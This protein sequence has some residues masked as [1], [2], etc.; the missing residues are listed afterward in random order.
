ME[1]LEVW[2]EAVLLLK[3]PNNLYVNTQDKHYKFWCIQPKDEGYITYWARIG[4]KIQSKY[5]ET[6]FVKSDMK[7]KIQSKIAKGYTKLS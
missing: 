5:I 4:T 7:K 1:R 6:Y 3:F 2:D